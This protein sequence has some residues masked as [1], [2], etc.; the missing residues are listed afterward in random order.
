MVHRHVLYTLVDSQ[1]VLS[2]IDLVPGCVASAAIIAS[3]LLR[4]FAARFP[5]LPL[6]PHLLN[7]VDLTLQPTQADAPPLCSTLQATQADA[8]P[9]GSTLQPTQ[10]DARPSTQSRLH[11]IGTC[12]ININIRWVGQT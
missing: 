1:V 2:G 8:L 11:S 10:V 9:F 3:P 7:L 4:L 6:L 12:K 5:A